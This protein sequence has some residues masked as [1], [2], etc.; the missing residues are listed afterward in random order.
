M[1]WEF[2]ENCRC[3]WNVS[4]CQSAWNK[5]LSCDS[6]DI[7]SIGKCTYD[8]TKKTNCTL[9]FRFIEWE[10]V[11]TDASGMTFTGTS[12]PADCQAG[13]KQIKCLFSELS[14]FTTIS[15]IILVILIIIFYILSSKKGKKAGKRKSLHTSRKYSAT[16]N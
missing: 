14:F 5:S 10:A 12:A 7:I 9:G 6:E 13:R 11:W 3:L 15:I 4:K 8:V 16:G 2:T 1:C